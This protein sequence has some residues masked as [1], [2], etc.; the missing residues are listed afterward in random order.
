MKKLEQIYEELL[1]KCGTQRWWPTTTKSKETEIIIGAILTQNTAWKNVEKA[2][3]SL[4]KNNLV[5]F[6]K[7]AAADTER[8][9][10]LIKSSGYYNQ[11]AKRLKLF[12]EHVVGNY[13]G[14]VKRML[15][16]DAGELRSELLS[17]YGIGP[18]TAD[19]II[20]YAA[21]KPV[22][23]IDAYTKRIFARIGVSREGGSYDELQRLFMESLP[24]D[25]ELFSE[26]HAL[27]VELG[28]NFCRKKPMCMDCPL[29]RL[30]KQQHLNRLP[31]LNREGKEAF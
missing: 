1:K 20:L 3:A 18:E 30:C 26:Y 7:I 17:L 19:S 6:R 27:V 29:K 14:S 11:K 31:A 10:K 28:K 5:D 12:A 2:I 23:V 22:F 21:G 16:K 13:G 4:K 8:L 25:A 24:L 15:A 9:A